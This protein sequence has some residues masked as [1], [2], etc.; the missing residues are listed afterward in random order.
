MFATRGLRILS[1]QIK[2]FRYVSSLAKNME[3]HEI[4]PDVIPVAPKEV[5]KVSSKQKS[6]KLKYIIKRKKYVW[7]F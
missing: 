2:Q 6:Y 1:N 5:C 4:V 7:I 3:S